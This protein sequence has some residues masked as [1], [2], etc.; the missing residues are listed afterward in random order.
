MPEPRRRCPINPE[1]ELMPVNLHQSQRDLVEIA[2]S[3]VANPT[4]FKKAL[5]SGFAMPHRKA[6]QSKGALASYAMGGVKKAGAIALTFIPVPAVGSVLTKA[7]DVADQAIRA[8][9]HANHVKAPANLGEKVKFELKDLASEV[10]NWDGYRWK[11]AHAVEQ[12]NTAAQGAMQGI[13]SAPCDTW[14]RVWAKYLYLGSRIAKL[15]AS[16]EAMRAVLLEVD[17][18]LDSVEQSYASTQTQ[19]KAQYDKDV[20][21]L[22][23]MQVHDSCSDVKCMFKQGQYTK[24]ASV[25][26]SDA[27]QHFIKITSNVMTSIGDP[28]ADIIAEATG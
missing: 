21:Q 22:K 23:T 28:T 8:K 19:L 4:I 14:V 1:E 24:Q 7:W 15:R 17:V 16:I 27:A 20:A 6:V 10:E 11:V 2:Q 12:Y 26:T 25:P 9:L 13:D 3:V 18:W 5:R